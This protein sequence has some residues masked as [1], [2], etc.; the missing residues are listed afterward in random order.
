MGLYPDS[1]L[2]RALTD[3]PGTPFTR[4]TT[5]TYM[6]NIPAKIQ[7][8][9]QGLKDLI[10]NLAAIG[11]LEEA[12]KEHQNLKIIL[13]HFTKHHL[14]LQYV[15]KPAPQPME[16]TTP[17]PNKELAN[18][19]STLQTLTKA[20][21]TLQQRATTQ[22][23]KQDNTK[24]PAQIPTAYPLTYA[25]AAAMS[26]PHPSI[27][28]TLSNS[29]IPVKSRP[30]PG[31]LCNAINRA[32]LTSPFYQ[33]RLSAARWTAKGN[34]ILTGGP[35]VTAQ[36]LSTAH[37]FIASAI[38]ENLVGN[39]SNP[40]PPPIRA[41]V[42]WSKILINRVPTG[43]STDSSTA[44]SREKCHEALVNNNPAY[45]PLLVTQ[46]PSWVHAPTSYKDGSSSSLVV[47]F[48]DPDGSKAKALLA[49]KYL[50]AFGTRATVRKWKQRTIKSKTTPSKLNVDSEED[51]DIIL[52]HETA[53][54]V[55]SSSQDLNLKRKAQLSP[56]QQGAASTK[57]RPPTK[58]RV[59]RR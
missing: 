34:L 45:A 16:T 18:I 6:L 50:Y 46:Q 7:I 28:V 32:L 35:Q 54:P 58:R 21:N 40:L 44:Y 47:A 5:T 10:S 8:I 12:S 4:T 27:V 42:K 31:L 51:V 26:T 36:L 38:A 11:Q 33:V 17:P 29:S 2:V 55:P 56:G 48:E 39:D 24:K 22:P 53:T 15:E 43:V 37:S 19:Q 13:T 9:N 49:T 23:K 59:D 52:D 3:E 1:L 30:R 20:I 14:I 57:G 25:T 41:N